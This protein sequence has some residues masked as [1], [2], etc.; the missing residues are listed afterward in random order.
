[1]YCSL[2]FSL[3]I[4]KKNTCT[5]ILFVNDFVHFLHCSEFRV[6]TCFRYLCSESV[7][8]KISK[9]L[10][11]SKCVCLFSPF[12]FACSFTLRWFRFFIT[13]SGDD[14]SVGSYGG[15]NETVS[16]ELATMCSWLLAQGNTLVLDHYSRA[17]SDAML[18]SIKHL[19]DQEKSNSGHHS[20]NMVRN[21]I[22]AKSLKVLHP[23]Y[24][25]MKF[26]FSLDS[27]SYSGCRGRNSKAV[28][29]R[30]GEV[31]LKGSPQFLKRKRT[32]CCSKLHK[33]WRARRVSHLE[34]AGGH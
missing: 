8:D 33:L 1:M 7:Q 13:V 29:T 19:V 21:S 25:Q 5:W 2:Q 11:Y 28:M 24:V 31:L 23:W 10:S 17:R 20:P 30:L 3:L 18:K 6:Y 16:S 4:I 22:Y 12:L 14:I 26:R 27:Y 15:I 9:H 34:G 32:K